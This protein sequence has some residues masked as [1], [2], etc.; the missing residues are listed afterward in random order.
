MKKLLITTAIAAIM[1]A[2]SAFATGFVDV[3][4]ELA[5]NYNYEIS[6]GSITLAGAVEDIRRE[7]FAPTSQVA[8]YVASLEPTQEDVN[9][10]WTILRNHSLLN[11]GVN[12]GVDA[13]IRNP[14]Y[15]TTTTTQEAA[16][17]VTQAVANLEVRF[18]KSVTDIQAD[19]K[20][21]LRNVDS[22]TRRVLEDTTGQYTRAKQAVALT[23][24][25]AK[26]TESLNS[27]AK[28]DAAL[29]RL[30]LSFGDRHYESTR[31]ALTGLGGR[32]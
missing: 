22:T 30:G 32:R 24:E 27:D 13:V 19:I 29:T 10:A 20:E 28:V 15:H 7:G 4:Q 18:G 21:N 11:Q 6:A 1:S 31:R 16:T 3:T 14:R 26:V 23:I 25:H 8:A 5:D 12:H 17:I 2:S 9:K